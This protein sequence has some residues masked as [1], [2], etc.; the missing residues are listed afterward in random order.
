MSKK[1]FIVK[2]LFILCITSLCTS[3]QVLWEADAKMEL[4]PQ[5]IYW[6]KCR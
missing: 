6:G 3:H 5:E 4:E 2:I 1:Y